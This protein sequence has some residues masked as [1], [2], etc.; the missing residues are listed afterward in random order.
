MVLAL[1]GPFANLV[2]AAVTIAGVNAWAHGVSLATLL[3][4]PVVQTAQ[5]VILVARAVPHLLLGT[6]PAVGPF[7]VIAQGGSFVGFDVLRALQFA[8]VMSVNL[9]VLNLLPIPPLDGGRVLLCAAEATSARAA[10]FNVPLNVAG[11]LALLVFL[12]W[13]TIGDL[14]RAFAGL[15]L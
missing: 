4:M 9:A 6:E 13:A 8:C 5:A 1:G 10:R 7:G 11:V 2:L 15:F 12:C 3:L 14:R